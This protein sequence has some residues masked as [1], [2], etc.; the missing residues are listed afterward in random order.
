MSPDVA[1]LVARGII[2]VQIDGMGT[3]W[4]GKAFHDIAYKNLKCG[5]CRPDQL[6]QGAGGR[7]PGQPGPGAD[8]H[9][10]RQRG[11]TDPLVTRRLYAGL[12]GAGKDVEMLAL[13]GAGHGNLEAGAVGGVT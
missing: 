9:L 11:W 1:A 7:L 8:R 4:R 12:K 6:D 5:A 3:N 2:V 10:W 13:A